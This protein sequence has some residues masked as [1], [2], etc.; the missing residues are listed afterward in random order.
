[1]MKNVQYGPV[2]SSVQMCH[3]FSAVEGVQDRPVTSSVWW[4]VR[5]TD[6]SHHQQGEGCAVQDCQNCSGVVDGCINLE[7]VIFYRQSYLKL[8]S[9]T[10]L[11]E[12][13]SRMAEKRLFLSPSPLSMLQLCCQELKIHVD[14]HH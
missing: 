14:L 9:G 5:S 6:L 12:K 13:P 7:K 10:K 1:M 11:N 4:R 2:T 3:I 8:Q